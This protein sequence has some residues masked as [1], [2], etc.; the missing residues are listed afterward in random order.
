VRTQCIGRLRVTSWTAAWHVATR[1]GPHI[2]L[3]YAVVL[4]VSIAAFC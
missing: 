2:G 3:F 4:L 1:P